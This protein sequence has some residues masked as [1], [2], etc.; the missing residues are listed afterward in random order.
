MYIDQHFGSEFSGR[1]LLA[2]LSRRLRFIAMMMVK[3]QAANLHP[4]TQEP[5]NLVKHES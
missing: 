2:S 1:E 5:L 4:F 3:E